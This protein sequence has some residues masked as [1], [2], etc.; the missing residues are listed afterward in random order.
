MIDNHSLY[1]RHRI[2]VSFALGL[3]VCAILVAYVTGLRASRKAIKE[4]ARESKSETLLQEINSQ[5]DRPNTTE[6]IINPSSDLVWLEVDSEG[7]NED[8]QDKA[9][10]KTKNKLDHSSQGAV[11]EGASSVVQIERIDFIL[12]DQQG[13]DLFKLGEAD[14][15]SSA[16]QVSDLVSLRNR[17]RQGFARL[18]ISPFV[19]GEDEAR[20]LESMARDQF[21][22]LRYRRFQAVRKVLDDTVLG[23]NSD[24]SITFLETEDRSKHE[25]PRGCQRARSCVRVRLERRI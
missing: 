22:L 17:I 9:K 11:I 20:T 18:E 14:F 2:Q 5:H 10:E 24:V 15:I 21:Y 4:S 25:L 12:R 7:K 16:S 19:D 1:A 3:V 8:P 6:T 23:G 13:A